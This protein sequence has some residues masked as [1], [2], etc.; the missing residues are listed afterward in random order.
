MLTDEVYT[1]LAE[2]D[3]L[4]GEVLYR[5]CQLRVLGNLFFHAECHGFSDFSAGCFIEDYCAPS[6]IC[7]ESIEESLSRVNAL[8]EEDRNAFL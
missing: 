5:T 3:R 8:I 1:I 7:L 2:I 4:H 6:I